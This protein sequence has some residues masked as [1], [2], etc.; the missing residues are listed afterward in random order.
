MGADGGLVGFGHPLYPRGDP[1]AAAL[2]GR[3]GE[4]DPPGDRLATVEAVLAAAEARELPD[5]NVDAALAAV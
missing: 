4:L 3:L 5:P 2:L 1:R